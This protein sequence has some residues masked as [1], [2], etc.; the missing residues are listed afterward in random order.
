MQQLSAVPNLIDQ[1]H[2]SL[3]DAIAAGELKPGQ[4]IRQE[5][6]ATRLG[7]VPAAGQTTRCRS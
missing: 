3:V 1:V 7:V 2:E 6:L 5:D 4:R